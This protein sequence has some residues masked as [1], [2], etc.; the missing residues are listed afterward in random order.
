MTF[1]FKGVCNA[2]QEI[3]LRLF[4]QTLNLIYLDGM[5]DYVITSSVQSISI[6]CRSGDTI[7][8][9]GQVALTTPTA[10][11][12]PKPTPRALTTFGVGLNN[13]Q[14]CRDCCFTCATTMIPEIDLR[15]P[16]I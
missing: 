3:R 6:D 8:Y 4:D 14:T 13:D 5:H 7:C 1:T 16:L 15:C 2:T 9:G 11:V 12:N 10:I